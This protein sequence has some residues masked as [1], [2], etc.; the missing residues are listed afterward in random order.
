MK[1]C[2]VIG[3]GYI[4]LPTAA[5]IAKS[6]YFVH[7]VDI[8]EEV[9]QTIN[10]GNVNFSEPELGQLVKEVVCSNKL[11][12]STFPDFADVFIIAV[13]T[14]FKKTKSSIPEPNIEYVL[15]ATESIAPYLKEGNLVIIESTSPVGTTE[16]VNLL[17]KNSTKCNHDKI[18]ICYCPERVIPGNILNELVSNNRVVGGLKEGDAELAKSF[19]KNFCSGEIRTTNCKTAELVK[20][21]ENTFRDI[22]IAFANELSII[23]DHLDVNDREL[24]NL[25][26]QHPRVNILQPGCGVGGHCI[27]IDP[28]FLAAILP[29]STNLIQAGRKVNNFKVNWVA[30]KIKEKVSF[31]K[32]NRIESPTIG[33]LGLSF[34]PN[35]D[36]VRESPAKIIVDELIKSGIKVLVCEP[37]LKEIKNIKLY[38]LN[39]VIEESDLIVILVAH[40]EFK[41]INL[42]QK[43]HIDFCGAISKS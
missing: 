25:A 3:L 43:L 18:H 13:P 29:E 30:K 21:T 28:W 22:N 16:K 42:K 14:P 12:A 37:N 19:Y 35:V 31:L 6:N 4:G 39:Q 33:C 23:C 10:D 9:V 5:L 17:L 11:K 32:Q 15:A 34:K 27:A 1:K 40:K 8:N 20:L 7:G 41:E 24:I 26:N 38:S 36:D 2:C